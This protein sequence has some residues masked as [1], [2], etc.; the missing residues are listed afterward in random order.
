MRVKI[1]SIILLSLCLQLQAQE[2]L[3]VMHY[4]LL[5]YGTNTSWCTTSN[6]NLSDKDDYMKT[7]AG[8][9][10]PDVLTVNEM[11]I[12]TLGGE[13]ILLDR[14]LQNVMNSDGGNKYA[15]AEFSSSSSS[16]IC[17]MIYYN[18]EKLGFVEQDRITKGSDGSSMVRQVDVY[19]LYYKDPNL[20]TLNDTVFMHFIVGHLKAGRN[21]SDSADRY[22]AAKATMQYI[23]DHEL[24]GNVFLQGD[25]NLYD[26]ADGAYQEFIANHPQ[27]LFTDPVNQEGRWSNNSVYKLYHTQSTSDD[28][29]DDCKSSGGL[30]D[31]FDFI[32]ISNAIQSQLKGMQYINNSYETI[33][34]DGTAFN[35]PLKVNGNG[36]VP[37]SVAVAL[38]NMSD[39][40]PVA[41]QVE[42]QNNYNS[43]PEL[44]TNKAAV[45]MVNPVADNLSGTITYQ[46][47]STFNLKLIS[48]TGQELLS[49]QV[50]NNFKINASHLPNGLYIMLVE[51][52]GKQL[53]ISRLIKD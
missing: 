11:G 30:D 8:Y 51:N 20:A 26:A 23:E 50:S 35:S 49:A 46:N 24:R 18:T 28:F 38:A 22:Y 36:S 19:K 1:L 14:F 31:R 6:N 41:L 12:S 47:L 21:S 7:I 45:T 4:N 25:F 42:V 43:I 10:Q 9:T 53:Y 13:N 48:L 52:E 29:N 39:H 40:L 17:N 44:T 16:E 3:K 27:Y 37:D 15:R 33:G 34:Q 32:L 2:T 5:Y